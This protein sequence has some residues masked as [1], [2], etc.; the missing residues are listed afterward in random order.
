MKK[1]KSFFSAILATILIFTL[2]ACNLLKT[3]QIPDV[4]NLLWTEHEEA[5][6]KEM[7]SCF[8]FFWEMAN[9]EEDSPGYGLI[10]TR[11]NDNKISWSSS[12]AV[13]G[14]GLAAIPI[15][16]EKGWISY[17]EGFKRVTGTLETIKNLK[18]VQ[19]FFYHFLNM[20]TGVQSAEDTE[21]S[22]IDTAIM[23]FGALIAGQYFGGDVYIKAYDIYSG[24]NW[25][26]YTDKNPSMNNNIQFRMGYRPNAGG[27]SGWWNRY[28]EQFIMYFLGA[29]APNPDYRI[30]KELF[31][32]FSREYYE[33]YPDK[34]I[35][36][37]YFNSFGKLFIHQYS[38]AFIDFRDIVDADGVDWFEN[39]VRASKAAYQY[40]VDKK[41]ETKNLHELSWGL[42]A[43]TTEKGYNGKIGS[44]PRKMTPKPGDSEYEK[45]QAVKYTVAPTASLSSIAFTP[46]LSIPALLYFQSLPQLNGIFGLKASY[47]ADSNWYS[48]DYLGI[49]KGA[50]LLMF[51]NFEN[52]FI[53]KLSNNLQFVQ[54]AI[55][56]LGFT[57]KKM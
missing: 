15:G 26:W 21:V 11:T 47:N 9:S 50:T 14:F 54:E 57:Y 48:P 20:E 37:F 33:G 36:P 19:G 5:L 42:T 38:H 1:F 28:S 40:A 2:S 3:S 52:G 16:I 24:I 27:F 10:Q 44:E 17:E 46:E 22:V 6:L 18:R 12:I 31:D 32:G 4:R 45:Y 39:S 30:G 13:V 41:N 25:K 35:E 56:R 29:G 55:E 49:D 7:K 34:N 53:W 23:I 8:D 43:C 51:A